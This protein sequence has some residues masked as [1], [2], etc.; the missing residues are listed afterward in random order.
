MTR[1]FLASSP[2][3][4]P[5]HPRAEDDPPPETPLQPELQGKLRISL[6]LLVLAGR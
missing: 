6:Y 4:I 1:V 3:P 5:W 2:G